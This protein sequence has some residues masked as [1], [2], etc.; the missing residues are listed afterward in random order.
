DEADLQV[1]EMFPQQGG[2]GQGL[3]GGDVTTAGH[4]QVGLRPLVVAGPVPDADA[5]GAVDDGGVHVE[6]LQLVLFVA[7]DHIDVVVAAQTVVGGGQQAV[8][9][10]RQ[11]DAGHC[12]ILVDHQ[13]EKARVLVGEAVVVLAPH[14][15]GDQQVDGG[16][17]RAPGQVLADR[18]PLGVLVEHGVN[19]VDKGLVGGKK[20]VATGEHIAL[21]P[22]FQSVFREHLQ[23]PTVRRQFAAVV[24]R[25]QAV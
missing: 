19:D 10:R 11:V 3:L 16:D 8:G 9:V 14:R 4:H 22:A 7:D 25:G 17:G 5:L 6:K 21:Q 2:G 20:A 13:I 23:H 12:R 1:G 18:Q 24:V 15:G